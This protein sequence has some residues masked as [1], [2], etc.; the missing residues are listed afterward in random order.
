MKQFV[1]FQFIILLSLFSIAINCYSQSISAEDQQKISIIQNWILEQR[2]MG[3]EPSQEQMDSINKAV[4]ERIDSV[5][6]LS[7]KNNITGIDSIGM[8]TT[9]FC[10]M[11]GY[12]VVPENKT[13]KVKRMFVTNGGYNII[14]NSEK[15]NKEFKSGEKI[16]APSWSPE[17]SLLTEDESSVT[18]IFEIIEY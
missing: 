7:P 15:Y 13:W 16:Y 14:M 5:S 2:K 10:Y 11:G 9:E 6:L 4:K 3:K 18:Y 8:L 17:S 12:L 1:I